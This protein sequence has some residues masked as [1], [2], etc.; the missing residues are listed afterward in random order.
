[1]NH[2]SLILAESFGDKSGLGIAILVGFLVVLSVRSLLV[3]TI[4]YFVCW[5][6]DLQ[7]KAPVSWF[8]SL[9]IAL[10][11]SSIS[12]VLFRLTSPSLSAPNQTYLFSL[13]AVECL[14]MIPVLKLMLPTT[15]RNS[16]II[17]FGLHFILLAIYGGV[18]GAFSSS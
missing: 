4:L 13:I 7:L 15:F 11:S 18:V 12:G 6:P 14:L 2:N 8:R 1:M 16:A 3:A 5:I 9:L 17:S 10:V